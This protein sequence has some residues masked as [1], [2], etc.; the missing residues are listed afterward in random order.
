M[1]SQNFVT[2]PGSQFVQSGTGAVERT[3]SQKLQDFVSVLD[4]G[5][6]PTGTADSTT[7][8]QAAI[9]A[10]ANKKVYIPAGIY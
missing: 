7:A 1:A 9:N 2:R 6:D 4:F 10:A 3:V 5:A 8:I